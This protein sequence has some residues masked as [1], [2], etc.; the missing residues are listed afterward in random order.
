MTLTK[1]KKRKKLEELRHHTRTSA[2]FN[3]GFH[4]ENFLFHCHLRPEG[5]GKL[6]LTLRLTITPRRRILWSA[7]QYAM[8]MY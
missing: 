6:S 4:F 5:K 8:K 1:R 7:K 2:Q 3:T